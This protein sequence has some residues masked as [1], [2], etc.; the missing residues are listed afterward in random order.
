MECI[1]ST[2]FSLS[3]RDKSKKFIAPT[4]SHPE[5]LRLYQRILESDITLAALSDE[6]GYSPSAIRH[7]WDCK[8]HWRSGRFGDS[9]N[10]K[11]EDLHQ[12]LDRLTTET[13]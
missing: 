3:A 11:V 6:A 8:P 5:G 4:G 7:S 2:R 9:I 12:A 1:L 13:G 10:R